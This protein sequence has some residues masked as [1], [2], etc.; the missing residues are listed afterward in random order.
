MVF[1]SAGSGG[2]PDCAQSLA[3]SLYFLA[4]FAKLFSSNADV[5]AFVAE[6]DA[7]PAEPNAA[8]AE[9]PAV[10]ADKAA[11]A[12]HPAA[13]NVPIPPGSPVPSGQSWAL[14]LDCSASP[15]QVFEDLLLE[16]FESGGVKDS[17]RAL[18]IL[19]KRKETQ[20][21]SV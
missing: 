2:N 18:A 9:P 11:A 14:F 3:A 15:A 5:P 17:A 6:P 19:G 1:V 10:P 12:A 20:E 13:L 16:L 21:K 8:L 4:S 7:A